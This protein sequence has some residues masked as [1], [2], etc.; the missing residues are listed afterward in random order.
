VRIDTDAKRPVDTLLFAAETDGLGYRE[1]TSM[2]IDGSASLPASGLTSIIAA[3][4]KRATSI[5]TGQGFAFQR[6]TGPTLRRSQMKL[7][8]CGGF[9]YRAEESSASGTDRAAAV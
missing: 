9:V 6:T 1:E 7:R 4:A 2:R 8:T 3:P 5:K